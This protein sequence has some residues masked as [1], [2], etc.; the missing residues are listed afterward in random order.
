MQRIINAVKRL[1]DSSP[2]ERMPI[3]LSQLAA[4]ALQRKVEQT[5]GF[6]RAEVR[7][8]SN[9]CIMADLGEVEMLLDN[10]IGNALKF[11]SNRDVP[12]VRVTATTEMDRVVV[13]VS[14]NG[15]GIAPEDTKRIFELFTRCH[16]GFSGSGVG[17]FI[18]RRIVERHEGCIWAAGELGLGT[19]ISFWI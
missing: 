3:D 11:S 13:H 1:E 15:V 12:E 18:A 10:L 17:L 6:E 14:D 16:S 5:P 9:I 4:R 8:Q 19:T 2:P 7:I